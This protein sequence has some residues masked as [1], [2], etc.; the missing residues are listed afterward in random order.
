MQIRARPSTA[1]GS[2][3]LSELGLASLTTLGAGRG[4]CRPP[5]AT[6]LTG[7]ETQHSKFDNFE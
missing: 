7:I 1:A 4:G 3:W 2:D 5:D 6:R